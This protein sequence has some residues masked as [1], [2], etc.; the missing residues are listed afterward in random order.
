MWSAIQ[1][2]LSRVFWLVRKR[3]PVPFRRAFK[4]E[5]RPPDSDIAIVGLVIDEQDRRLLAGLGSR[6]QWGVTFADN[7]ETAQALSIQ[8]RAAAVLCD[9][10]VPGREWREVVATLSQSHHRPCVLLVSSVVDDYLWNEVV[11]RGG[12]DVLSKPLR[13]EDL[14]RA[15]KL[16]WAYWNSAARRRAHAADTAGSLSLNQ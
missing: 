3:L 15:I 10:Y 8:L 6:N 14:V 7:F 2:L 11:R 9:R 4:S 5:E 16:A 13:E 1:S 12:Y